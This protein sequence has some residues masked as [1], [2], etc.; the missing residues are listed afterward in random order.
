VESKQTTRRTSE[1]RVM[2]IGCGYIAQAEHIPNWRHSN[3]GNIVAVVD[4]RESLARQI[5]TR[6]GVPSFTDAATALDTCEC[7]IVHI[8][9]PPHSHVTL[10]ELAAQHG[11]HVLVEKPLAVDSE[12]AAR[13]VRAARAAKVN[14]MVG[15][16][17]VFDTDFHFVEEQ[18]TKGCL[19][20][21]VWMQSIWKLSLPPVYLKMASEPRTLGEFEEGTPAAL[22]ARL[23]EESIHHLSLFQRW[24]GAP[25]RVEFVLNA[26][27]L[28]HVC[29][30]FNGAIPVWHTNTGPIGHGEELWVYGEEQAIYA[31]PWSPHFPW[32]YGHCEVRVQSN[33]KT[34]IP[35][36]ARRN[37]YLL[38]LEEFV[39]SIQEDRPP[40]L[41]P[42]EAV[43]DIALIERI[44][45]H[46]VNGQSA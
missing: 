28:W 36:L 21:I 38:M 41:D 37:P 39:A 26:G 33:G 17:R 11:K 9:T 1:L 27:K 24:L 10:I 42:A 5:G 6:L 45:A 14:L 2:I 15:Y 43:R 18:I 40:M 19:G 44:V 3:L 35:A 25:A 32:T 7:D 23:L 4:I 12:D 46:Y 8:C 13:A 31:R 16:P 22:Q 30:T 34:V 20:N 29:L